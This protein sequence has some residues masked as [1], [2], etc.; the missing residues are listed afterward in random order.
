M[1]IPWES[2]EASWEYMIIHGNSIDFN[3][4]PS[5]NLGVSYFLIFCGL[6]LR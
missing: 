4:T 2:M 5:L 3:E 1:V 6:I